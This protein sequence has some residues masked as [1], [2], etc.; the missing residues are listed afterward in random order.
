[1]LI[2]HR[3]VFAISVLHSP[4]R[5]GGYAVCVWVASQADQDGFLLKND[6]SPSPRAMP[7]PDGAE[8]PI[9]STTLAITSTTTTS[10]ITPTGV[11]VDTGAPCK[12]AKRQIPLWPTIRRCSGCWRLGALLRRHGGSARVTLGAVPG[13]RVLR[14]SWRS[15]RGFL[16]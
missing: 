6:I 1:M 12:S 7:P 4:V 14:S 11:T 5:H 3:P 10:S 16:D 8:L 9:P 13:R 15:R 2:L